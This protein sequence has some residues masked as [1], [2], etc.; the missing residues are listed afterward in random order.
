MADMFWNCI[1]LEYLDVSSFDTSQC[2]SFG[3]MF[4]NCKSLLSLDISNFDFSKGKKF[5]NMFNG[6]EKLT[7]INL[8]N[9]DTSSADDLSYM[10]NG[11]KSL[12]YLNLSNFNTSLVTNMNSIFRNCTS[13]LSLNIPNFN[14][15]I[16]V[17]MNYMF[18]GCGNLTSLDLS[19][20][21][22][23]K[24]KNMNCMFYEC[25]SLEY[26][27][28]SNF[29][30]STVENMG[31]M[32]YNC[33]SLS[34]LNFSNFKT[35][36]VLYMDYMFYG[37]NNLTSLDLSTFETNN[38]KNFANMFS[39]CNSLT[40]LDISNFDTSS[41]T[42]ERKLQD[43]F[44]N[45]EN[46][47]FI[48]LKNYKIGSSYYLKEHHFRGT[49]IN[50]VI[51][52]LSEALKQ[53]INTN[54][55]IN[56]NC[57]ENWYEYKPKIYEENKCT[58]DCTLT[59]YQFEYEYKC[60]S[61]CLIGTYNNN[62]KC[63]KCHPDC[64]E[65]DKA[66]TTITT[67]CKTCISENKYLY[68]G[69]CLDK[70]PRE[71][72]YY[73]NTSI[74][75][76]ICKCEF[77]QCHTC[78]Q[79]SLENNYCTKC[80][81]KYYPIYDDLYISKSGFL[82]CS[83]SPKGYYLD[84]INSVYKLCYT[85][86][87]ICNISG[88]DAEHNCIEC[89]DDYIYE[90]LFPI[91]KNCYK[92]CPN[93]FDKLIENKS[94][95]I[96]DCRKDKEY[97][98]EFRKKCY[99]KCPPGSIKRENETNLYL[100]S[101]DY[102]YFCKPICSEDTPF[103]IIYTQQCVKNCDI[104][105]IQDKSCILNFIDPTKEAEN[106]DYKREGSQ[107]TEEQNQKENNIKAHDLM[108]DNIEVGFTKS[109]FD[110]SDIE[111]GQNSVVEFEDMK[112]TLTTTKNQKDDINNL[113]MTTIDLGECE[114]ILRKEYKIPDDEM[115]F[116][117]KIDVILE[118]MKIPKIEYDVYCKLNGQ[119]LTKL[120][121]SF[122]EK[123]KVDISIP[124]EITESIDKLN[125]SSGY[126]NDLCYTATSESGTDINLSDRKN[127]FVGNNITVCQE[128]CIFSDYDSNIQKAKCSCDV[129]ES[130]STFANIN[131]NKTKLYENFINIRNIANINLLSCYKVLFSK[132]G[133]KKNYGS[134]SLIPLILLH[135]ILIIL[136]YG[137]KYYQVIKEKI[138]DISYAINNWKLVQEERKEIKRKKRLEI[139]R[140]RK[141][142]LKREKELEKKNE[143]KEQ[144][145]QTNQQKEPASQIPVFLEY[146]ERKQIKFNNPP[147][148]KQKITNKKKKNNKSN[149]LINNQILQTKNNSPDNN[150]IQNNDKSKETLEKTKKIMSYINEELNDMSFNLAIKYDKRTYCQYYLSL[151]KSKHNVMFTFFNNT[152][153][154]SST[155]KIDLFLFVFVLYYSVN[156]LFFNDNT[157][158]KIYED[159]GSFNFIY[160]LPQILYSSLISAIFNVLLKQLALSEGLI[161]EFKKDKKNKNIDKR[162]D[163]LENKLKIKFA[164]YF[165]ISTIFLLFFWYYLSMFCAIYVNTQIHLIKDTLIS[166]GLSLLYPFGIY[167]IPGILR[168]PALRYPKKNR[169]T[170]YNFS[171]ILQII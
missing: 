33:K 60:Y 162:K 164:L 142:K 145:N 71:K 149:N 118:G 59:K 86:C 4:Y 85:T 112:I 14:T 101:L 163:T 148:K 76:N 75:Q 44:A 121:L 147:N 7:S 157:M 168:I 34:S 78:T 136:F 150:Q 91:Y 130:S 13:L 128:G 154:N 113:N 97:K 70:C 43:I 67:N 24:V 31:H 117:K 62:Y 49:S 132:K 46:L 58:N 40:S 29:D 32:F 5:D 39:Y 66:N 56:N 134:F 38:V 119:N 171:K 107:E 161:L 125:S 122:C 144:Q 140:L 81:E 165:L 88:N 47:E 166:F 115:I 42:Q 80:E 138:S 1:S 65:C 22:T 137:K 93:N 55:C 68:L 139:I 116:M 167:L 89:K 6:C 11:C 30:T 120:N 155:V 98:F 126:Y 57:G 111:N 48:N 133:F 94:E 72:S 153:Y 9:F 16:A 109:D 158:H 102:K 159:K 151:L 37:C 73:Y 2:T 92:L 104:K 114:N 156:A 83:K 28:V 50:L 20:F 17:Y 152:D 10:F 110:T 95:C 170:M 103:E 63:K 135:F 61:N 96:D 82:N 36:N 21:D 26:L 141:E 41:I 124:I 146:L 108:L 143:L 64:K 99:N 87:K 74:K 169:E 12:K 35:S 77:P 3:H 27:D 131:I 127:E 90:A 45:C 15:T 19:N 23:S 84:Y 160:Q 54:Q 52:T 106:A 123:S 8:N 25:E 69:N 53:E 105:Y 51:C 18:R 79:E 129:K 100:Y